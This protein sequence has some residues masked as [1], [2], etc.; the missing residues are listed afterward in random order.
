L[1]AAAV[2][3]RA[4]MR[5][6]GSGPEHDFVLEQISRGRPLS[7]KPVSTTGG[8]M[9]VRL[10]APFDAAFK[11]T[12]IER[13]AGPAA[14]VCAYRVARCVALD[15]VPPAI[16][17]SFSAAEI[18]ASLDPESKQSWRSLRE[19]LN[20]PG[21]GDDVTVHGA[22]IFWIND[23]ADVGLEKRDS[24]ERVGEWLRAGGH[25]P[26]HERSLAASVSTMLAFDYLIGNFDRWSGSNVRGDLQATRV[27]VRD[28]D[29]AFPAR[30]TEKLHRRLW[31][32]LKHSERFSRS[33]YAA[34]KGLSRECVERELALDPRGARGLLGN[35]QLAGLFDRREALLSYVDSLIALHGERNVLVFD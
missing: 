13:P 25:I 19:R 16:S 27:Y 18:R 14:E 21:D 12:T 34:I 29:L 2:P 33:F 11:P 32:D 8:V 35:R 26:K 17:R 6:A 3:V 10:A 28:H 23:L 31:Q 5:F 15:S 22:M 4:P 1:A 24:L 9:R 7:F 30:M 20:L